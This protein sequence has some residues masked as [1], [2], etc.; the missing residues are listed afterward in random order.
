MTMD[1][2]AASLTDSFYGKV[3]DETSESMVDG[4]SMADDMAPCVLTERVLNFVD[5]STLFEGYLET[6]FGIYG[7]K[8]DVIEAHLVLEPVLRAIHRVDSELRKEPYLKRK[9]QGGSNNTVGRRRNF[10]LPI[11]LFCIP[12]S[13]HSQHSDSDT[14]PG[15]KMPQ[16]HTPKSSGGGEK[17]HK[18]SSR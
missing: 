11:S 3:V 4:G 17:Q 18:R 6:D 8:Q 9:K 1:A 12:V 13:M 7:S 5:R 2:D 14:S 15:A 16:Q 10:S